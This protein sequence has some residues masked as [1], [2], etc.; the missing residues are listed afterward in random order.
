MASRSADRQAGRRSGKARS[1][2]FSIAE[3]AVEAPG[4][5]PSRPAMLPS[6]P[7]TS[8]VPNCSTP[9]PSVTSA[10]PPAL[11]RPTRRGGGRAGHPPG[12]G[13]GAAAL[14]RGSRIVVGERGRRRPRRNRRSAVL[15]EPT[16][17]AADTGAPERRP[18]TMLLLA[19]AAG[20]V[21]LDVVSKVLVV[22]NLAP[23][24]DV[25]LLGGAVY[26]T[27]WRNTG[28]A[29]SFAEGAT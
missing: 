17:P 23:G 19:L 26:L 7:T 2:R 25:R 16:D 21:V 27:F 18:R 4:E 24:E 28:A 12:G 1:S 10:I 13:G 9:R 3:T 22:A 11:D 6:P 15:A 8:S 14:G 5:A 20:V 29:F